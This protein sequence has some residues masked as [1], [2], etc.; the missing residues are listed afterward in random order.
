M[1][2][3]SINFWGLPWPLSVQKRDRIGKLISF[4]RKNEFDII[5]LQE[6]W[7]TK[8]LNLLKTRLKEYY[9]YDDDRENEY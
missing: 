6:I 1:K 2:L 3:T 5:C 8:D 4:I 9:F 7:K